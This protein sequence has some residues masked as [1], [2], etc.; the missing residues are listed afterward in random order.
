MKNELNM[1]EFFEQR[2]ETPW[3]EVYEEFL[4]F[5][6][7]DASILYL[8]KSDSNCLQTL[9]N[10][11]FTDLW[12]LKTDLGSSDVSDINLVE[13][14]NASV[15]LDNALFDMVFTNHALVD[16][17]QTDL[18]H[19][20][21]EVSRLSE[22]YIFGIESFYTNLGDNQNPSTLGITDYLACFKD[23]DQS[24]SL[25]QERFLPL[26]N[27]NEMDTVFLLAKN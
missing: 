10:R 20:L 17:A 6:S 7:F 24:L 21:S 22:K 13:G 14:N 15:P 8:N 11:G 12:G 19:V 9:K 1:N 2:Y 23:F 18:I 25:V 16:T 5:L 27:K 4:S 3:T 26:K